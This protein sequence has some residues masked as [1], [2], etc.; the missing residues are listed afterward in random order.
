MYGWGSNA[1]GQLGINCAEMILKHPVKI[2]I[3]ELTS[4]GNSEK[5]V[6]A[7]GLYTVIRPKCREV[8][9]SDKKSKS[10]TK[11]YVMKNRIFEEV[12]TAPNYI[13]A[14]SN[15]GSLFLYCLN[16]RSDNFVRVICNS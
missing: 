4:S 11:I 7:C 1:E 8:F 2:S 12:Y 15:K 16:W 9:I 5:I 13:V 3:S 14:K 6:K 10:F